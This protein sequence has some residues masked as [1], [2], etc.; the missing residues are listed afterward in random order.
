MAGVATPFEIATQLRNKGL[1]FLGRGKF[2]EKT[3]L[4]FVQPHFFP[5]RFKEHAPSSRTEI[6]ESVGV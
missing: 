1:D 5:N 4:G 3:Q 2:T 6:S